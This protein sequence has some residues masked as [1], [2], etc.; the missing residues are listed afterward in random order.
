MERTEILTLLNE[1]YPMR[2]DALEFLRDAG[3]VSYAAFADGVK[4][5]LRVTKPAYSDT[6]P[7]ALDIHVFLQNRGF[8]GTGRKKLHFCRNI[9]CYIENSN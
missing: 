2:F 1:N 3:S 5:F 4:Y 8:L 6:A 9:Q 7:A